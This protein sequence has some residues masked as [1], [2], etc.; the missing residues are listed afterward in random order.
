MKKFVLLL[1]TLFV[2]GIG[3]AQ[4]IT[5]EWNGTLKVQSSQLRIVFQITKTDA[6]YSATM[7]SPDQ[8]AKDIPMSKTTF[9]NS[10]LTVEMAAANIEYSGTLNDS[11]VVVGTFKQ[12]GQ[13]FPLTLIRDVPEKAVLAPIPTLETD[14]K[15][16]DKILG[17]WN[18]MLKAGGMQMRLVFN[19]TKTDAGYS[20]TMDSPDQGAKG[21]PMSKVTFENK[22][23]TI[24]M[25]AASIE[26]SGTLND[27]DVVVGTF[28]QAGQ[29][30]PIN[31]TRKALEKVVVIRPQ[32]PVKPYPYYSEEVTFKNAKD[33]VTLAGTLTLPKKVGK[34][35]VVVL[36]TG[37]GP[38]NR[39]EELMGHKPFLVLSDYLTRNG[40]GVL[41]YDDRGSFASTGNFKKATTNDFA[42]DV[43]SAVSYLKTRKEID[44]KHIGLIGHSE[45]G[46]I[47]PIV[48]VNCKAVSFIVLMAGTAIPGSE[49]LLLQQELIGRGMGMKENELKTTS[50]INS[51]IF[52]M[53]DEIQDTDTLKSKITKYLLTA[54]KEH[55]EMNTQKG[56]S[57]NDIVD[58]QISQLMS[59]WMLNFI[60]YNPALALEKVKCPVLAINGSK[61]L[62][63]PAN[64]NL[65]AI[66]KA[67]KKGGN[68]NGT[69]KE[70]PGLNHL[71]QECKT[72]LP[73]EYAEIEQT[74]SPVALETMTNWIKSVISK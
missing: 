30:F 23:L 56:S 43:E 48:A 41:R 33:S 66:E 14:Q 16:S 59:P 52:K 21:I 13:S 39:D 26:Y 25:A 20:A 8:G 18:G 47:A 60:R 53:V 2:A 50:E 68:K 45:G 1:A 73:K 58:M 38:Q 51:H 40:I 37:S 44:Q 65:P 57:I 27:S 10:V 3:I 70:L 61:D 35:P 64:V 36:I 63:V 4:D 54:L 72:G 46:I 19:I 7:D 71:F 28:K 24:E 32:D 74:I 17:E 55:P 69:I 34:F 42:T 62:Q 49:L 67:L 22:V 31:L 11:G 5:G 12:S 6:G 9:E 29:S 15:K